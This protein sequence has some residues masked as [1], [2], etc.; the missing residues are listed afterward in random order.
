MDKARLIFATLAF[1]VGIFGIYDCAFDGKWTFNTP[2]GRLFINILGRKGVRKLHIFLNA[3]VLLTAIVICV[4]P[5]YEI[6][7]IFATLFWFIGVF[8]IYLCIFH[9]RW[10]FSISPTRLKVF[11]YRRA[12]TICIFCSIFIIF[13]SF[14]ICLA[15]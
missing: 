15:S 9:W 14:A 6:P 11:G 13:V 10:G 3:F 5:N 12:K 8:N 7:F 2:K 1:F 4:T